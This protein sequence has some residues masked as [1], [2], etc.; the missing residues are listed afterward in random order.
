MEIGLAV[1]FFITTICACLTAYLIYGELQVKLE[2]IEELI[3][4]NAQLAS[5]LLR[6]E[7]KEC[8]TKRK[9]RKKSQTTSHPQ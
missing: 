3:Q 5:S 6:K 8:M 4:E 2:F 9:T 7:T 1:F